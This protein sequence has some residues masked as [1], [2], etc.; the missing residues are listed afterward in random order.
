MSKVDEIEVSGTVIDSLPNAM[1]K[2][3]LENG[4]GLEQITITV[5]RRLITLHFSQMGLA[6]ARTFIAFTSSMNSFW[7]YLRCSL[8]QR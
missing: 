1:F 8:A 7:F 3:E 4:L 5:P 6:E 2:V